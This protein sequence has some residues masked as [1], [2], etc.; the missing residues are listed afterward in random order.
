M[1]TRGP[2]RRPRP[3][4]GVHRMERRVICGPTSR[5]CRLMPRVAL[6]ALCKAPAHPPPYRSTAVPQYRS[7]GTYGTVGRVQKYKVLYLR[8]CSRDC[9]GSEAGALHAGFRLRLKG[10]GPTRL[11]AAGRTLD[12]RPGAL[13]QL[14]PQR[15]DRCP[16]PRR[17]LS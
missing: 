4:G 3:S 15:A 13:S 6:Q 5:C 9:T 8:F 2:F 16:M 17:H 10:D 7:M 14:L 12:G 1:L 11:Q